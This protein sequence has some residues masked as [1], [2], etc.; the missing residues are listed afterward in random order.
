[1]SRLAYCK[2]TVCIRAA[3]LFVY[4]LHGSSVIQ[5]LAVRLYEVLRRRDIRRSD[6]II[7][8][9]LSIEQSVIYVQLYRGRVG[10]RYE[11]RRY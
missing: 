1:M 3:Y 10:R 7:V 4:H 6:V 8:I 2:L 9:I 11:E 5:N